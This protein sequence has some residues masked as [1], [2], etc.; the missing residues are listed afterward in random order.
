MEH[1]LEDMNIHIE[2]DIDLTDETFTY[3][4]TSESLFAISL[5]S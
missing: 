3:E 5:S 2:L 1:V 4:N